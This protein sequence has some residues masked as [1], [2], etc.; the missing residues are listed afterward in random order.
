VSG[1]G[2]EVEHGDVIADLLARIS[3]V[4]HELDEYRKL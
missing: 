2:G 4:E 1:G 3:K